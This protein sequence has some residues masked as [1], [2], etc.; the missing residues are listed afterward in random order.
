MQVKTVPDGIMYFVLCENALAFVG[1]VDL[2]EGLWL[3]QMV[4]PYKDK[5][6]LSSHIDAIIGQTIEKEIVDFYQWDMQVQLAEFFEKDN[7]IFWLGDAAH[8][9]APTGGLGLNTG[10]GDSYNLGWKLAQAI[11]SN[12]P[13]DVLAT[14]AKERFPVWKRN[15]NFAKNN[16]KEFLDIK[17]KYPPQQDYNAYTMAYAK[18]ADRYLHSSGLTLGYSYQG[19]T[20]IRNIDEQTQDSNPFEYNPK[21]EPGYFLPHINV[22]GASIYHQLSTTQWNLVINGRE[23]ISTFEQAV[24]DH[25]LIFRAFKIILVNEQTYPYPFLLLRPDWHIAQVAN[26]LSEITNFY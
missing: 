17:E 11:K 24:T 25:D 21:A 22:A 16:A 12:A 9:F 2:D 13:D 23:A 10:F 4:W 8:A 26:E 19:S 14:Y 15:L 7:R 5:T 1:P 20:L 18:L 3:A 6:Q